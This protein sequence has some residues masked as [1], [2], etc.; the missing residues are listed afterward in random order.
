MINLRNKNLNSLHQYDSEYRVISAFRRKGM[1][2]EKEDDVDAA[3]E[4][5]LKSISLGESSKFELFH[6]YRLCYERAIGL[7]HLLRINYQEIEL[8]ENLMKHDI[9]TENK[10]KYLL[11]LNDLI[12]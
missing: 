10:E 4:Y 9:P 7:C 11:R 1:Q 5:Y 6:A 3:L 12:A 8:I 2:A